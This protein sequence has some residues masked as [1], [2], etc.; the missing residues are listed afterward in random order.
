LKEMLAEKHC[1]IIYDQRLVVGKQI[2]EA[3]MLGD[4]SRT[5]T[6]APLGQIVFSSF[7]GSSL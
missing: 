5:R 3:A 4:E 6:Q 7:I 2:L 1:H